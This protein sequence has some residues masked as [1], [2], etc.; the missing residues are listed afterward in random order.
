MASTVKC[1]VPDAP[2]YIGTRARYPLLV[3]VDQDAVVIVAADEFGAVTGT[4][5]GFVDFM[6]SLVLDGVM[7][8][9]DSYSGRMV[10]L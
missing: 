8:Q 7:L 9:R 6:A 10:D 5:A 2:V 3:P 1:G 4:A